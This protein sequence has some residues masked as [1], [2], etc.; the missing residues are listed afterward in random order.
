VRALLDVNVLIALIDDFHP[1]HSTAQ[2][3]ATSHQAGF[4]TCPI[5]QNGVLRIMAN[6]IYNSQDGVD[7][8]TYPSLFDVLKCSLQRVNHEFWPDSVSLLNES[9]FNHDTIHSHRQLTDIYLLALAVAHN[10]CLVTF[11]RN[12]A[13]SHVVGAAKKHLI[14]LK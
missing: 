13:L 6:P 5:V 4:A 14:I 10:G 9:Q 12:I 8:F 11:D 1:H 7:A 3:W 2:N